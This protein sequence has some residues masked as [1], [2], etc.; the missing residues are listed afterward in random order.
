LGYLLETA[1]ALWPHLPRRCPT[2]RRETAAARRARHLRV[3]LEDL[4]ATA[5]KV[6]QILSSRPDLVPPAY[7]A[8]LTKLQDAAPPEAPS[9]IRL[10]VTSEFGCRPEEAYTTFDPRPL[11]AA[12][13]GEAH[14]ATLGDGQQVVVKVRRPGVVDQIAVDL[15][16]LDRVTR[17]LSRASRRARRNDLA[18]LVREFAQTLR[19]ELDYEREADNCERFAA[20][21]ADDPTIHIPHV[22]RERTTS[23]VITLERLYGLR[24]DDLQGL[25]AAGIG[26]TELAQRAAAA[27]LTM[28]F[29]HGF[30]HA[31]PHPGNF[32][33]EPDGRIGLIDFGMVGTMDTTTRATLLGI[34]VA[35]A[36]HDSALLAE[37]ITRIGMTSQPIDRPVLLTDLERLIHEQLDVPLEEIRLGPLLHQ[38]LGIFR[39]HHLKLPANLALLAKTFA[40]C[41]GIAAQLDPSFRMTAAVLPYVQHLISPDGS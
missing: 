7:E 36:S 20:N 25:T 26:R 1:T 38:V 12:S 27:T 23:R 31:D 13:I 37:A 15:H 11:A 19:A 4:G 2:S 32:F 14:A 30:F 9:T 41:E 8:E 17:L 6:G 21:F 40:M 39:R 16:V 22:F 29:E 35:L 33:V 24:I 18:G 28:V 3:T 34:L 5:I 10:V